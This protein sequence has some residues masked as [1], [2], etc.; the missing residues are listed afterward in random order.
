MK[1]EQSLIFEH[2]CRL[3]DND[4]KYHA[5]KTL[6]NNQTLEFTAPEIELL[7]YPSDLL[8]C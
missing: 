3:I 2:I 1:L 8:P 6:E 4:G 5:N 7:G